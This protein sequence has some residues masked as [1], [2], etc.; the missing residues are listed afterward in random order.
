M[1]VI[2]ILLLIFSGCLVFAH[3]RLRDKYSRVLR[4]NE[5]LANQLKVAE[6]RLSEART[7]VASSK[8]HKRKK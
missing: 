4:A 7:V 5:L 2:T 6:I 3:G 8:P 1:I